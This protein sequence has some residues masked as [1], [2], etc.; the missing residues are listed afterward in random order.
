V[1]INTFEAFDELMADICRQKTSSYYSCH[2]IIF[3]AFCGS[4]GHPFGVL[5][6]NDDNVVRPFNDRVRA[7]L[8]SYFGVV[9]NQLAFLCVSND[10]GTAPYRVFG[11]ISVFA[12]KN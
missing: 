7:R 1:Y 10:F 4:G 8:I 6:A 3:S 9:K 2:S 5:I 11:D 12:V